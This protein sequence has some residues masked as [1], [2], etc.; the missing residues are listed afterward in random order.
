MKWPQYGSQRKLVMILIMI[1]L[2][3]T[4]IPVLSI[5]KE[6]APNTGDYSRM[7]KMSIEEQVQDCKGN[8]KILFQLVFKLINATKQKL[9]P[10]YLDPTKVAN[11]F[12]N[13]FINKIKKIRD[14]LDHHPTYT[15]TE[16]TVPKF[17]QFREMLE[18]EVLT[19]INKIP[20]K[21]CAWMHGRYLWWKEHFLRW[22]EPSQHWS[23]YLLQ[24]KYLHHNGR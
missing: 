20:A 12:A 15:T 13:F 4:A 7:P 3:F 24:R 22:S 2:C 6:N 14:A 11:D 5:S 21:S 19:I 1:L 17:A 18:N 23:T 10:E 8:N 16:A 9:L